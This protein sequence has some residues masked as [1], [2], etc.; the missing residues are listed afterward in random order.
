MME[1]CTAGRPTT[2]FRQACR[3]SGGGPGTAFEN[4]RVLL[5]RFARQAG[6]VSGGFLVILGVVKHNPYNP[7][8][9]IL[10]RTTG[11]H[12]QPAATLSLSV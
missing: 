12:S 2:G 5:A 7:L 10:P 8:P 3:G 4:A 11:F 9:N 1:I 6:R